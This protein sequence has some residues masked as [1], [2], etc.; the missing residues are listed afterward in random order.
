MTA[1]RRKWFTANLPESSIVFVGF[2]LAVLG[3]LLQN[4]TGVA[5]ILV[6]FGTALVV[7]GTAYATA[8]GTERFR[9]TLAFI[10]LVAAQSLAFGGL[11]QLVGAIAIGSIA[12]AIAY[13]RF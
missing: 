2:S 8:D 1:L 13:S 7:A 10:S 4:P 5:E 9:L 11:V 3:L 12:V 6:G